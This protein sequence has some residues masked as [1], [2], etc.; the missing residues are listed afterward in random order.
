MLIESDTTY[1]DHLVL[2]G[3]YKQLL[4]SGSLDKYILKYLSLSLMAL[5][6]PIF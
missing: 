5:F 3:K 6:V 2:C 1:A 4:F